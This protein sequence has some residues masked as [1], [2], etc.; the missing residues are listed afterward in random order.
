MEVRLP[1]FE[2]WNENVPEV[3]VQ[4]IDD[5]LALRFRDQLNSSGL[6]RHSEELEAWLIDGTSHALQYSTHGVFR[7]FGKFPPPIAR[8]LM[9]E[10]S[11]PGDVVLGQARSLNVRADKLTFQNQTRQDLV[12]AMQA[13]K[14]EL[15]SYESL[16]G[17]AVHSYESYALWLKR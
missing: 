17:F 2:N 16:A 1:G 11:S 8:H 9:K 5:G 6:N 12:Q 7:F 13:A 3:R 10:Y 15:S 4:P 14:Y